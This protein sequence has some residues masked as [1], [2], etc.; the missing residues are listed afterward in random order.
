MADYLRHQITL[1]A[2]EA[3]FAFWKDR[4]RCVEGDVK[5]EVAT[6]DDCDLAV[7]E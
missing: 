1:V 3:Q 2:P 4:L 6:Q 5:W 7:D